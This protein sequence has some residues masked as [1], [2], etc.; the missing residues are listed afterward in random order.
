MTP[1]AS[2]I[3]RLLLTAAS[4]MAVAALCHAG[5]PAPFRAEIRTTS[6]GVAHII[7]ADVASVGFGEGYALAKTD[8]CEIAGRWITVN[9]QRSR[10]FGPDEPVPT[11]A[12]HGDNDATNLQSDF[13]WQ[14]I[15]DTDVVGRELREAPPRGPTPEVRELV[16]GYVA[17]YN[18]YLKQ[19]GIDK[20]PDARCRGAAWVRPITERDVYLRSLHWSLFA[21]SVPLIPLFAN[22]APPGPGHAQAS[23]VLPNGSQSALLAAAP[24]RDHIGSNMIALGAQATDNGRGMLFANPHWYWNGPERFFETQLTVPGKL[25]VYGAATLGMPMVLAGVTEHVAWSHTVST[26]AHMTLY[27][28]KLAPHDP[29]AYLYDGTVRKLEPRTVRVQ[30]KSADGTLVERTHTFWQSQYGLVVQDKTLDW[31]P[32]TAYAL[33]DADMSLYWMNKSMALD[34]AQ[35]VEDIQAAGRRYLGVPWVNTI[36]ADSSGHVLYAD[37]TAVPHVSN[38]VVESCVTSEMGKQL[39]GAGLIVL[40]G[41]RSACAWGTDA[42]S[43]QP[44][45]FGPRELPELARSDY[46]TNSNDSYWTDNPHQLLEGFPRIM[47]PE[48]TMRTLRTRIGLLKIERRLAGEDGY[49][50]NRFTLANLE[51]ITMDNKVLSAELWRDALVK[52]CRAIPASSDVGE[53]CEVLAKWDEA[54]NLDSAG[55]VLWRR[56]FENLLGGQTGSERVPPELFA[57]AFDPKDPIHTPRDLNTRDPRVRAALVAAVGDL[58]AAKIPLNAT[59]RG[60][61]DVECGG[62]RIPIPGGPAVS[63]QYNDINGKQG[64]VSP[65]GWPD[66]FDGS[67][68]ILW[69]R[70]TDQGPQGRSILTYSQSNNPDSP[71]HCDQTRLFSEHTSKA[72]LFTA[73]QIE[74]DPNL[75]V[76]KVC[77]AGTDKQCR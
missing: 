61:Q 68:F 53:A 65:K 66:V 41:S 69:A 20:I 22:A 3:Q 39:L 1:R 9:A 57:V 54:E 47:G 40:D 70:F 25:N 31:S 73:G 6:H 60:Y 21:T 38:A 5:P 35:S 46:V 58:R 4:A 24:A 56:F 27:E 51:A 18:A 16:R 72:I 76:V 52:E 64:W 7:A 71:F 77:P 26:P 19:T 55:A 29:R 12:G 63:G 2:K 33:R 75:T 50:G 36:A 43:I 15:L 44:G 11:F 8:V 23:F 14:W 32:Q 37:N 48:R 49:P 59:L 62:A 34:H 17:G 13:Y 10:Y 42:D 67:S 28:L 30:A 74:A 45:T